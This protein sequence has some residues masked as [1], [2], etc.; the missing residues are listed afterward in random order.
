M[1]PTTLLT[2]RPS[3][4]ARATRWGVKARGALVA[5]LAFIGSAAFGQGAWELRV[6]GYPNAMPFMDRA[7]EGFENRVAEILADELGA[8]LTYNW[9]PQEATM[10]ATQLAEGNCDV[11]MGIPDGFEELL[12]T[13]AY[14]HA[15]YVFVQRSDA[16]PKIASLDDPR[17]AELRIGVQSEGIPPHDSLLNRGLGSALALVPPRHAPLATVIE[18][19]AAGE[20][21]VGVAWGPV[22]GHYAQSLGAPL[23]LTPVSPQFDPPFLSMVRPMVIGVR[24]GDVALRDELNRAM[25]ARWD[26]I[27]AVL[28]S[29]GVLTESTPRPV[30]A[31]EPVSTALRVGVIAPNRTKL[32]ARRAAFYEIAGE[33]AHRGA[34]LAES[35]A[36]REGDAVGVLLA[37]APSAEAAERAARR[38]IAVSGAD[39]LVG[40]LGDGE[41]ERL[42]AIAQESRV[43]FLNIGDSSPT[44]RAECRPHVFH[45]EPSAE[46]YLG[47]LLEAFTAAGAAEFFVVHEESEEGRSRLAI[48]EALLASTD[49][50]ALVGRAAVAPEQPTYVAEVETAEELGA[51]AILLLVDPRDQ[52]PFLAQHRTAGA[53]TRVAAYPHPATQT[54][55]F[56]AAS[57]YQSQNTDARVAPWDPTLA[58]PA[59]DL[60][61]R[62]ASRWGAPMDPSGWSA[63]AAVT[64][65]HQAAER[66]RPAAREAGNPAER[67]EELADRLAQRTEL[68]LAKGAPAFFDAAH[69]LRHSLYVVIPDPEAP[70]GSA[71]SALTALA[72][73]SFDIPAD[74][75]PTGGRT[76]GTEP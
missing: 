33:A 70:Y 46:M 14:Y 28:S 53:T 66:A 10:L 71:A 26:E 65:L 31:P 58:G 72:S 44:L 50:A 30:L 11:L 24:P 42:A 52:I 15:P 32:G 18:A 67:A 1:S 54:R 7:E 76:C 45:V 57:R 49:G 74:R 21:D 69:Q 40:G 19:V 43:P 59:A 62:F 75:L 64:I 41:A 38:L 16:E 56:L 17:L 47:A 51:D 20:I 22:A 34:L 29:Y 12:T 61:A 36:N 39:A 27:Q 60:N 9:W 2:R 63:Y 13:V 73:V 55:D 35:D 5:V 6:C 37:S 68:G 23:D 48:A 3:R 4:P 25:S 8:T